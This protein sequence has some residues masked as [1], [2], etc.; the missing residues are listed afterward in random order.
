MR[1]LV[2]LMLLVGMM[3]C[4]E[5]PVTPTSTPVVSTET[6]IPTATIESDPVALD[7]VATPVA[8]VEA[9]ETVVEEGVVISAETRPP[10][11]TLP[12]EPT[13]TIAPTP[14]IKMRRPSIERVEVA[15]A[16]LPLDVM[17][18]AGRFGIA[19]TLEFVDL[20]GDGED[21]LIASDNLLVAI[22][23]WLGNGYVLQ[24]VER[25]SG[26]YSPNAGYQLADWTGDGVPE[27]LFNSKSDNGGTG[28]Y[29]YYRERTVVHCHANRCERVF[30]EPRISHQ[31]EANV[32]GVAHD[33]TVSQLDLASDLPQLTVQQRG[34]TFYLD[35]YYRQDVDEQEVGTLNIKAATDLVY[36]WS[37]QTFEL[38]DET[39]VAPAQ[40][41]TMT[42]HLSATSQIANVATISVTKLAENASTY[43]NDRCQLFVNGIAIGASLGCKRDFAQLSWQNVR[44][45]F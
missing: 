9:T 40:R 32:G 4:A 36:A 28:Y 12:L 19:P 29:E 30:N 8:W 5:M 39:I 15:L 16:Q 14:S 21:D 26:K 45:R 44:V 38:Q 43:R 22:F 3:A 2:L 42:S 10:T 7:V 13:A 41:I 25:G 1:F 37:G 6:V 33:T 23:L 20:N 11:P 17:G 18:E 35:G 34:F 27:L 31:R 24:H